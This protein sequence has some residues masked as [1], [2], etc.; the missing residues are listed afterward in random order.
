MMARPSPLFVTGTTRSGGTLLA[1]ALS[2]HKE[3]M[4]ASD[5]YL[6]VFRSLRNSIVRDR[7]RPELRDG[8][9]PSSTFSDYYFADGLIELMDA[10]QA[11]DLDIPLDHQEAAHLRAVLTFR[12]K[13]ECPDLIPYLPGLRGQSYREFLADGLRIVA[14]ARQ[15]QQGKW[16]GIKEVWVVDFLAALARTYPDARFII[17]VRDPRACATS[18]FSSL[19]T[20]QPEVAHVLSYL[21]QWRKY[22]AFATHYQRDPLVA[23]RMMVI[24]YE[25]LVLDPEPQVRELCDFLEVEYDSAML[26]TDNYLDYST[27][28]VWTGNSTFEQVTSGIST[29]SIERWRQHLDPAIVKL[30]NLVC[31][32][33]MGLVGYETTTETDDRWPEPDVLDYLVQANEGDYS[34]RSDTGDPQQDYGFELFRK[35]LLPLSNRSLDTGLVRRSFLFTD[36]FDEIR[37]HSPGTNRIGVPSRAR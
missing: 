7:L 37:S 12:A 24:T 18:N 29:A 26:D 27:G 4:V 2:A 22:I 1:R 20:G 35:A 6:E 30:A 3:I 10:I 14:E 17:I 19:Q 28:E 31:G 8:F 11:A 33:E 9:D 32:P 21:R 13:D 34:W 15:A 25:R 16:V 5:P 36:V 23:D